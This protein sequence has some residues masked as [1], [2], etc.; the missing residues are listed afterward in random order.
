MPFL[1]RTIPRFSWWPCD[2][3]FAKGLVEVETGRIDA[4][5]LA[6]ARWAS[7]DLLRRRGG[8]PSFM[9]LHELFGLAQDGS[10]H[11]QHRARVWVAGLR[12]HLLP[13]VSR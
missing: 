3:V 1:S 9:F 10:A 12:D 6:K 5:Q 13:D 7:P 4:D 11:K 2:L 8:T